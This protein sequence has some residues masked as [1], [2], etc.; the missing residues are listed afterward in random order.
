MKGARNKVRP[1]GPISN[2]VIRGAGGSIVVKH[3]ELL[4]V[5]LPAT[6]RRYQVAE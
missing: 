1:G 5:A 4:S 3:L 2:Y 6:N